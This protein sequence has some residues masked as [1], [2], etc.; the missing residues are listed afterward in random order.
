MKVL[1]FK[2]IDFNQIS[3]TI[4]TFK[5]RYLS[6]PDMTQ[7]FCSLMSLRRTVVLFLFIYYNFT[8]ILNSVGTCSALLPGYIM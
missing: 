7:D 5:L 6:Q 4:Y 1:N 8:S 3:L 2:V